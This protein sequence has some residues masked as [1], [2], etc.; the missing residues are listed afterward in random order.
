MSNLTVPIHV[1]LRNCVSELS[2]AVQDAIISPEILNGEHPPSVEELVTRF[3]PMCVVLAFP[4]H[5]KGYL[6]RVAKRPKAGGLNLDIEP[7]PDTIILFGLTD[8]HKQAVHFLAQKCRAMNQPA[9]QDRAPW[10]PKKFIPKKKNILKSGGHICYRPGHIE[11]DR[12]ASAR[13]G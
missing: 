12:R 5:D 1:F 13:A 7:L 3:P 2:P 4:N 11:T 8:E 10:P 6:L 9:R